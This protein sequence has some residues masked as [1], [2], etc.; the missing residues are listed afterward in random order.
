MA[1]NRG[2]ILISV[3]WVLFVVSLISFT[4]AV[5][6]R[7][8]M[9][10]A[11]NTFDSERAVFMAKGA[12]ESV[13]YSMS[14]GR[15]IT[16]KSDIKSEDGKYFFPFETGEARVRLE[17]TGG[18]IDIN[19]ASDLLL[20]SMFDSIGV[21]RQTRNQLV[22]CILDWRDADDIPHLYGAEVGDY[23]GNDSRRPEATLPPNRGFQSE[24]ELLAVRYMTPDLFYGRIVADTSGVYRRLPG[25]RDLVT[26]SSGQDKVNVNL[27]TSDVLIALPQM[28]AE[29][30]SHVIKERELEAFKS[31]EDLL[32]RVPE[33]FGHEALPF[34]LFGSNAP[35]I[36]VSTATIS[37]S[38]ASRTVRAIFSRAEKLQFITYVPL[39][40][41]R[42][43]E[44]RLA[45]WQFQ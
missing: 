4:L 24:D 30:A 35:T 38:G 23:P 26:V 17:S 40:Y 14:K 11:T 6:V 5:A 43:E 12:A 39:I 31:T 25:I 27:A 34:L 2:V 8:E 10:T 3:L 36:L 19:V 18:K 21:D 37:G 20:A 15:D 33:M 1:R 28:N 9:S 32:Q 22:D 41:R 45:R 16:L 44:L 42:V 29:I 13:Y 7:A